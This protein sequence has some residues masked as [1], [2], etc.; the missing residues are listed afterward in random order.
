[1][2]HKS[3]L[4]GVRVTRRSGEVQRPWA[5][6]TGVW[7]EQQEAWSSQGA[8]A[9]TGEAGEMC[10]ATCE[11]LVGHREL[12]LSAKCGDSKGVT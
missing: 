9:R 1:M 7:E 8:C 3:E 6:G 11:V 10:R 5:G 2:E 4:Y 12:R